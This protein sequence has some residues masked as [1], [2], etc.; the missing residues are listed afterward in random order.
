MPFISDNALDAAVDYVRT[1]ATILHICSSEPANFAGIAAVTLGNKA[2]PTI[3]AAG[4]RSP[5]GRK[6]TV[7]S[8]NDGDVTGNGTVTHWAIAS[9]SEL[10]AAGTLTGSQAVTNGNTFSLDAFDIGVADAV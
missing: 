4:D 6:V 7:A 1:N 8:F 3:G 5:D 10:L 9:G 2:T